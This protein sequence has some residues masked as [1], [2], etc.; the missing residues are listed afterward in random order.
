MMYAHEDSDMDELGIEV[1]AYVLYYY[2]T[3]E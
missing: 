1:F 3:S 2:V